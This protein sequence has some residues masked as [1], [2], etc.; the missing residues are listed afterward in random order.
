ML[1][2]SALA[3]LLFS[4][5]AF[6]STKLTLTRKL[7][8][9]PYCRRKGYLVMLLNQVHTMIY[10]ANTIQLY[11]TFKGTAGF[12]TIEVLTQGERG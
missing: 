9:Q 12:R 5:T 11:K 4:T 8:P 10:T 2:L 6:C 1:S 3:L 7:T